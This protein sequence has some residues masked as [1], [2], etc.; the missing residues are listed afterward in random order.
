[1]AK[2]KTKIKKKKWIPIV[3]P[4]IFKEAELGETTVSESDLVLGKTIKATLMDLIGDIKKQNTEISF[5]VKEI[6]ENKALTEIVGYK[7]ALSSIRR[8]VRRGKDKVDNSFI[9]IT[10]DNKKVNI[11][12]F[13]VTRFK[14]KKSVI[15]AINKLAVSFLSKQIKTMKYED[16]ISA[17]ISNKLTGSLRSA[18]AK[19]YPLKVCLIRGADLKGTVKATEEVKEE[20]PKVEEKEVKKEEQKAEEKSNEEKKP[21]VKEAPKELSSENEKLPKEGLQDSKNLEKGLEKSKISQKEKTK[22]GDA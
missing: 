12:P 4:K 22:E 5:K 8:L 9:C 6:K 17:L 21:E 11:K 15:N 16:L 7:I 10:A 18:M 3:A 13:L 19:I 1:M 20:E 14:V 2:E